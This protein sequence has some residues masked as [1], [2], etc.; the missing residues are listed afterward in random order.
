MYGNQVFISKQ[1]K[2]WLNSF[3]VLSEEDFYP[4]EDKRI[5]ESGVNEIDGDYSE[6]VKQYNSYIEEYNED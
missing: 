3:P 5:Y 6:F 2:D 1:E 4:P